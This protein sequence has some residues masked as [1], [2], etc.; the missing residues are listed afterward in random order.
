MQPSDIFGSTVPLS[1]WS[2]VACARRRQSGQALLEFALILVLMLV[3]LMGLVDY[4]R[5][6]LTRQT[7]TNLSRE[8][9]NLAA[10][11]TLL[12]DTADALVVSAAPLNMDRNGCIIVTSITRDTNDVV[13]IIGQEVRGGLNFSSRVGIVGASGTAVHLPVPELPG[14]NQTLI[15]AEVFYTFQA[16]TPVGN[17]LGRALP[18]M[19]YDVAYF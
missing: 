17:L 5:I 1:R 4:G 19:L 9:A 7:L 16:A 15:A 12:A 13:H 11:G 10:R 6:F 2:I 18:N 3:L 8:G 14:T